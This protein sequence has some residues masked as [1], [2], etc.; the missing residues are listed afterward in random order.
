MTEVSSACFVFNAWGLSQTAW[1]D[2]VIGNV[3]HLESEKTQTLSS[4]SVTEVSLAGFVFNAWGLRQ[5]AWF[6]AVTSNMVPL[7][8]E[9]RWIER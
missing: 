8:Q 3:M 2:A 9:D 5:S 7:N 4:L 6:N 1:F